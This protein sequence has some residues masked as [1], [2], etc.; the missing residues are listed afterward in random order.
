MVPTNRGQN[1]S[2]ISVISSKGIMGYQIIDGHYNG[3][4]FENYIAEFLVLYFSRNHD[5]IYIGYR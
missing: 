5:N 2:L 1:I 3:K 4:I